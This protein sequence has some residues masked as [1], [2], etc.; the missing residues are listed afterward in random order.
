MFA[1]LPHSPRTLRRGLAL[2]SLSTIAL[3]GQQALAQ[4]PAANQNIAVKTHSIPA[5]P[6]G[7]AL[8]LFAAS[9]GVSVQ[10]D[11]T[12][13]AGRRAAGLNGS[14]APAAGFARLLEGTGLQALE[15]APAVYVLRAAPAA[16]SA[17]GPAADAPALPVVRA[18][19][20]ALQESA[21]GP[22]LGYAAKRSATG[23]KMDQAISEIA[24]SVS[25]I[26]AH[27]LQARD[28][29]S[30]QEA[31]RYTAGVSTEQY[32]FENRG[33]DWF[34][35]RGFGT[36]AGGNFRDGL[37]LGD[38]YD[39]VIANETYGLER[40]EILK[41]PSSV[42][43]G[44]G[45]AG[46]IVN[47]VSK[48]PG[49]E[50]LREVGVQLGTFGRK[51]LMA[52]VGGALD[53]AGRL[54]Y[55]LVAT[56]LDSESQTRYPNGAAVANKRLY[57]APSLLWQASADTSLTLLAEA[58]D[59]RAGD[60][61]WYL[62]GADG[63]P[64]H[65]LEGEPAYSWL[66]N[67]H[68]LL[69]YQLRHRFNP[70]WEL[71]Q[72]FR[73]VH[74]KGS[75]HHFWTRRAED[76]YTQ[77]RTAVLHRNNFDQTQLD[78]QLEGRLAHGALTHRLL[79]GLDWNGFRGR[80]LGWTAEAPPLD[81][82]QPIYGQA[83]PE[84]TT[85]D[86]DE[87]Q[88]RQD[89]GFYVQ[90]QI[91]LGP[92]WLLNLGGRWDRS[93]SHVKDP[94]YQTDVRVDARAFSGRVGLSYR[95]AGG[96]TPYASYAESFQPESGTASNGKPFVPTL[97]RQFELGLKVAP[98]H[99]RTLW[100]VALFE[101]SKSN[102]LTPDRA[103]PKERMKQTGEIRSR[104][105]ELE[106]RGEIA[107]GLS[108]V[109]NYAYNNVIVTRSDGPDLGKTPIQVPK[110]MA[111]AWLDYSGFGGQLNGLGLAVGW[112]HVGERQNDASNTAA[113]QPA[114]D[115]ADLSV[116]YDRGALRLALNVSNALNKKYVQSRAWGSTYMGMERNATLSAKYRF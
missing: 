82:R 105:L 92:Q 36:Q 61:I 35:I 102:V 78:T 90:D 5:G 111:S 42:L 47:R 94:V 14:F 18:R 19:A 104:G 71:R 34:L 65:V 39:L 64:S 41:G 10:L 44:Q 40:V 38:V 108:L 13:V 52:D 4:Q 54:S 96:V 3:A 55:R 29:Q 93:K 43:F 95:L 51:Q 1:S 27:E 91:Q 76:G 77:N 25:V 2:L 84:P 116:Y 74:A 107:R 58:M 60:D 97:G 24:Q 15:A 17:T 12:L 59:N 101:L 87:S 23:G 53:E 62:T 85:L 56:G 98:E 49:A 45:D 48:Q 86:G 9:A 57:V 7:E 103:D 63:E 113:P 20:N 26:A 114:Y 67:K 66:K 110:H 72:N 112:R 6:L 33:F 16:V 28:V 79:L 109:G 11:P 32:G 8:A 70:E 115:L 80:S 31:L 50:A 73:Q 81:L 22:V 89:L 37:K 75:K 30:V 68:Q 46:G 83:I 106:A 100:T 21:N 88:R 69:G 99:G